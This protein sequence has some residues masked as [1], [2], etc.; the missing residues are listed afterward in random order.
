V[1]S[2]VRLRAGRQRRDIVPCVF[3]FGAHLWILRL[4]EWS[5]PATQDLRTTLKAQVYVRLPKGSQ[6]HAPPMTRA[7]A[8]QDVRMRRYIDWGEMTHDETSLQLFIFALGESMQTGTT[9]GRICIGT[10]LLPGT[11]SVF[12]SLKDA[13]QG[14]GTALLWPSM[15]M[16]TGDCYNGCKLL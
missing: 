10:C 11:C 13:I 6:P 16:S 3:G 9:G 4:A 14:N 1:S 7:S 15:D 8:M 12:E 5:D 2:P